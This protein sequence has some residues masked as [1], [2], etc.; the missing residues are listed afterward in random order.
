M[1]AINFNSTVMANIGLE[2]HQGR[3]LSIENLYFTDEYG[4]RVKL[5]SYFKNKR[6]VLLAPVYYGC[7]GV[8]T[9]TLNALFDGVKRTGLTPGRAI[10][11]LAISINPKEKPE[12]ALEKKKAYLHKYQF[13]Q[14]SEGFHF[15]I[16]DSSQIGRV[17]E[18]LGFKYEQNGNDFE[19]P[20]AVFI[21]SPNGKIT[22][23]LP[24]SHFNTRKF[25]Q[26]IA[27]ASGGKSISAFERM[28]YLCS[29]WWQRGLWG[30]FFDWLGYN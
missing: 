30:D 26:L 6:P 27:A 12:L 9:I 13:S 29:R 8:C 24:G 28:I 11:I 14:T 5:S 7:P 16:G 3:T 25:R 15:L 22:K 10:Q 2:D 19:H 18:E 4:E 20:S 23:T 21:L 17:T 1:I